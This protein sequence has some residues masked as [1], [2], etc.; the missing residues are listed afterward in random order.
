MPLRGPIID[1]DELFGRLGDVTVVHVGT[2]MGGGD[3]AA[4]FE[5]RHLPGARFVVLD[6]ALAGVAGSIVGRH[7]L[8]AAASF[9]AALG[10]AGI[11]YGQP[12][13]AC[14]D[15]GGAWAARLVWMLRILGQPAALLDGGL[16]SWPHEMAAGPVEERTVDWPP[17]PWPPEALANADELVS[18]LAAGGAVIDSRAPERYRGEVEPI[19][20]VA[21]HVPGAM[22]LPFADNLVDGRFKSLRDQQRRFAVLAGNTRAI[23]YCGSGVTACHNALAI[24]AAGLPLPRVYV[25]SWSGWSTDP[26]RPI[27]TG[28]DPT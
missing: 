1:V 23:V 14:D 18:H 27:A 17:M 22:N 24:E 5:Q 13:V 7:P 16:D 3:P 19:D 10:A 6:D 4:A 11:P 20:A 28:P 9:A 2:R 8:P 15:H 25:G 26:R 21:G 12:V